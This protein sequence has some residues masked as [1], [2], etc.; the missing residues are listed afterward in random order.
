MRNFSKVEFSDAISRKS[1]R[2][3]FSDIDNPSLKFLHRWM[4][5]TLFP[6]VELCSIATP[7][8]MCLFV[9]VNRIKYTPIADIVDYFKIVHKKSGPIEWTSMVTRIT[10]NLGCQKMANLPYIVGMHLFVILTIL[11]TCTSCARNPIILYPYCRVLRLSSYYIIVEVLHC[12][13]IRWER[14]TTA[15]Q[16][17]LGLTGELVWRQ[18]NKPRLHRRLTLRSPSGTLGMG[19][20]TWLTMRAEVT[21]PLTVTP[22][23]ASEL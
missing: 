12:S 9:V 22:S 3:R 6:M 1:T 10:M 16:D 5:F 7:E 2:L 11:F 23:P 13:L 14:C 4:S 18:H 15:L 8:L 21:I 17:D 20:A 19:L